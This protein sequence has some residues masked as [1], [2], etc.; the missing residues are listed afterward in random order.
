MGTPRTL[1]DGWAAGEM[2]QYGAYTTFVLGSDGKVYDLGKGQ[3]L[4]GEI[5]A[6]NAW[7]E[8]VGD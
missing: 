3:R 7:T 5:F 8:R 6:V 4:S 1:L 2:K